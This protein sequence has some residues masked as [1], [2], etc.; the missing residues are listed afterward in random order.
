MASPRWV[1]FPRICAVIHV[2]N[3]HPL[4]RL[5]KDAGFKV[6][7][8]MMP[9][10]PGVS[11]DRDV[12]AFRVCEPG[13]ELGTL[14]HS[15]VVAVLPLLQLRLLCCQRAREEDVGLAIEHCYASSQQLTFPPLFPP[16]FHILRALPK[17]IS[18]Y[19]R[20]HR[21]PRRFCQL[22]SPGTFRKPRVPPRR[23]EDLPYSRYA[24]HWSDAMLASAP[25]VLSLPG[26]F[27]LATLV[28]S[29]APAITPPAIPSPSSSGLYELWKKRQYRSYE[30]GQLVDL[31]ARALAYVPP[32][33]R[34]FRVQRS[35]SRCISER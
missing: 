34:I 4:R 9:N 2:H 24:R 27:P 14:D 23:P 30:P 12:E 29:P 28:G 1:V 6:C 18:R 8:H 25:V 7:A 32:W 5:C 17:T 35:A 11:F 15:F 19:T 13:G 22:S 10:L 3:A 16:L 20:H 31:I 21:G 33:V 26:F